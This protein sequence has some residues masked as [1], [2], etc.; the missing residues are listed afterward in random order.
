MHEIMMKVTLQSLIKQSQLLPVN[1]SFFSFIIMHKLTLW[2]PNTI[3]HYFC[4]VRVQNI[5]ASISAVDPPTHSKLGPFSPH[6]LPFL[7]AVS[8]ATTFKPS[9][10]QARKIKAM[11]ADFREFQDS[12][13]PIQSAA[14]PTHMMRMHGRCQGTRLPL[15]RVGRRHAPRFSWY[16][17]YGTHNQKILG[18]ETRGRTNRS[19]CTFVGGARPQRRSLF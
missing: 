5:D 12:P 1:S 4:S 3:P 8:Q 19:S 11:S 10:W 15:C 9:A 7:L 17:A 16:G 2:P 13:R 14:P 6:T 18:E